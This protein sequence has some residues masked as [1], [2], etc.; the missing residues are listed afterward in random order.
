MGGIREGSAR[1]GYPLPIREGSG[2]GSPQ[3]FLL[4]DLKIEHF[5]AVFK[6][7][8]TEETRTQLQ[9]ELPHTGYAYGCM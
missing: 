6:V 7:D 9:E 2:T 3:K 5:G 4:S 8:L 1:S